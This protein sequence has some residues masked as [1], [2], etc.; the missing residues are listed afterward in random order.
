[1]LTR[2]TPLRRTPWK[3]SPVESKDWRTELHSGGIKRKA[4]KKRSGH[5]AKMRNACRDQICYLRVPGVCHQLEREDTI[6]PCHSNESEH[7]K[8]GM[9]KADDKYTVPGCG[10]CHYWLD[11]GGAPQML[12]CSTWRRA[13]REW[14]EVRDGMPD[15]SV[16]E[17]DG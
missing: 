16:G 11:F 6:V 8:A 15:E 5:D 1:M 9:R 14:S 13:Y 7:G 12:K 2:K 17:I 3:S 4:R 10:L